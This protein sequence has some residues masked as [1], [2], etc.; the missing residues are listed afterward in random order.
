MMD[1]R[2]F[3]DKIVT[4][5]RYILDQQSE[6]P[7]ATGTHVPP[8]VVGW[9]RGARED[10]LA[11]DASSVDLA[12]DCVP[13][14]GS[15]LPL[16]EQPWGGA[17]EEQPGVECGATL[18]IRVGVEEHFAGGQLAC[19]GG[20]SASLD[21]LDEDSAHRPKLIDQL[22]VGDAGEVGGHARSLHS[23]HL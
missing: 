22:T 20:L 13:D 9:G 4:I 18:C 12:A 1:R 8:N 15:A 2:S 7:E 17:V 6:H 21:T 5:E 3:D 11:G 16:V 19:G 23:S 14:A 10:E